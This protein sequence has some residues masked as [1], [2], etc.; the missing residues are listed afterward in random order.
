MIGSTPTGRPGTVTA[1]TGTVRVPPGPPAAEVEIT[2][3][4]PGPGPV[5][6]A[7]PAPA[8]LPG[9][10]A[11]PGELPAV[12]PSRGGTGPGTGAVVVP[13][14]RAAPGPA[15]P[16]G[17]G[18]GPA[19]AAGT[20]GR[21]AAPAV[22]PDVS[23]GPAEASAVRPAMP[24]ARS[25]PSAA[26][27]AMPAVRTAPPAAR[28]GPSAAGAGPAARRTRRGGRRSA[29]R[30][31]RAAWT[32]A[33]RVVAGAVLVALLAAA[34]GADLPGGGG[35]PPADARPARALP[36][37]AL[38]LVPPVLVGLVG[39]LSAALFKETQVT[40][41]SP[42]PPARNGEAAAYAAA[43][44]VSGTVRHQDGSAVPCAA[45]TLIDAGGRQSG[46]AAGGPDGRYTLSSPGPGSY[47][48]IATAPGHRPCAVGV[49]VQDRPVE[50]DLRLGGSGL[51]TGRVRTAEG[52]PV[53]DAIVTVTD[54]GGELVAGARSGP[55][56]GYAVEGLV[57]GEYTLAAAATGCR[58]AALPV[59][60]RGGE[61][62]GQDIELAGGM[63]LR[64]TVRRDGGEP[65]ADARVTVLD[66][67]GQVVGTAVTG[68]DGRFA[69]A[70]LEPGEYTLT[71]AGYPPVATV[72]RLDA[73]ARA[74]HD[75]R[76]G[77]EDLRT[78][79][80]PA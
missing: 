4:L 71:A 45:L 66:A 1:G 72:L 61:P 12:G 19:A 33:R 50:L 60:V 54:G 6:G 49:S 65:V 67:A 75:L 52:E 48:L 9:A 76:L 37:F 80:P 47:V 63:V 5:P 29:D 3:R 27:P 11:G 69:F 2:L 10:D 14:Q 58:P 74:E 40:E 64:G 20:P 21:A 59:T 17:N 31:R 41:H 51:L 42:V 38:G 70:D 22:R 46:R 28:P 79:R 18:A 26:R 78:G 16:G 39:L 23:A 30:P 36:E 35:L 57:A 43:V 25:L 55:D 24:A 53:A 34:L 15:A 8:V 32:T 77:H 7:G 68:A 44:P 56:G 73:T 62:T 13:R